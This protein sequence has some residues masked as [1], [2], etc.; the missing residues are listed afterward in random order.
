V[1]PLRRAHTQVRPYVASAY[2]R[3]QFVIKPRFRARTELQSSADDPK[4]NLAPLGPVDRAT[5]H[6]PQGCQSAVDKKRGRDPVKETAVILAKPA[7][8]GEGIIFPL[9]AG[10]PAPK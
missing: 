1:S 6:Q 4:K 3:P 2:F 9:G 5:N 10:L 7:G 8:V